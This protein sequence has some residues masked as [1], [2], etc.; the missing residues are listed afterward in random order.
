MLGVW[1]LARVLRTV[2]LRFTSDSDP[3]VLEHDDVVAEMRH[4]DVRD[5][6]GVEQ[7][8][9]LEREQQADALPCA[10]LH[11]RVQQLPEPDLIGGREQQV[12]E[13][14]DDHAGGLRLLDEVEQVVDPLVDVEVDRRAAQHRDARIVERPAEAGGDAA[15]LGGVLLERGQ[16]RRAAVGGAAERVVETHQ[17]LADARRSGDERRRSLPVAVAERFVERGDAGR[18]SLGSERVA[19]RVLRV[20]EPREHDDAGRR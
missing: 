14:V 11:Q 17:R 19:G 3:V 20:G 4:A 9:D 16:D 12:A 1:S 10:S 18:V 15:E 2:R 7:L 5:P 8:R 6:G 13:A